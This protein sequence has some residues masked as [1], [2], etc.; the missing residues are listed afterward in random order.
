VTYATLIALTVV[1]TIGIAVVGFLLLVG[2]W[3]LMGW[4]D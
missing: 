1:E 4:L 2:N 3:Y